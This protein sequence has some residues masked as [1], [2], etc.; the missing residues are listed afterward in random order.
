MPD[1]VRRPPARHRAFTKSWGHPESRPKSHIS[2]IFIGQ[3]DQ[4]KHEREVGPARVNRYTLPAATADRCTGRLGLEVE[5]WMTGEDRTPLARMLWGFVGLLALQDPLSS[6]A[7]QTAAAAPASQ[8]AAPDAPPK[9]APSPEPKPFPVLEYRIEGNTL[10]SVEDVERAV[11]PYLGETRTIKDIEA[12][13]AELEKVYHDRGYKT[14][15]VNIPQQRVAEGVVRLHVTEAPVGKLDVVGS[16]FHSLDAIRGKLSELNEGKVPDFNEV[17]KELGTVNRSQDLQ[18]TPVLKASA[19]PG[20]VDVDLQVTDKLP[21]HASLEVDNR[22]IANT[23]HL[24]ATGELRY[25]NLFQSNQSLDVQY[26]QA[27]ER[28]ADAKVWSFSYVIPTDRNIVGAFYAIHNGSDIAA[29]GDVNVIGKGNIFGARLITSLPTPERGFFHSFTAGI[30][31]KDQQQDILLNASSNTIASPAKY[32]EFSAQYSATW[33]GAA[34]DKGMPAATTGGVSNTVLDAGISFVIRGVGTDR[35]DFANRRAGAGPSF[36]TFRPGLERQQLLPWHW[37]LVAR[38]D[39]QLASGPL[40]NSEEY[41]AGGAD[42]VRGYVESER[43]ADEGVR[44]SLELRTPQLLAHAFPRV[45][46]SYILLFADGAHLRVLQP[47]P[48]QEFKYTLASAGVGLRFRWAG[49][50]VSLDGARTFKDGYVTPARRYRGLFQVS[51]A[52]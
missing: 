5:R 16:R 34:S 17:Q 14:V 30:D 18:V 38:I 15:I 37:S 36:F 13:R 33:L 52:Y 31:Y 25:D 44:G 43:L 22:Y 45:E 21:V 29:V 10:L 1:P 27:P 28:S 23:T 50:S 48:E 26:Q 46:R 40:I 6:R 51:Y 32:P 12:A 49:L 24:R 8:P 2:D 47:L 20:H 41:S 7:A 11:M 19:Q 35:T 3:H 4:P 9:P 39:G 42:S